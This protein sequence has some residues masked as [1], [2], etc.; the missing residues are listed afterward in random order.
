MLR[1]FLYVWDFVM[2]AA[3]VGARLARNMCLS[4]V[5][6]VFA[7]PSSSH[8]DTLRREVSYIVS[9]KDTCGQG[10]SVIVHLNS[11]IHES[12]LFYVYPR[13]PDAT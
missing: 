6:Q 8:A 4:D 12:P 11:L 5:P 10:A 3:R 9:V 2:L 7:R 1:A 13:Y